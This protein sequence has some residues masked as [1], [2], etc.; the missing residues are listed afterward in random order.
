[1]EVSLGLVLYFR[2]TSLT[3]T[4]HL[5]QGEMCFIFIYN[6]TLSAGVPLNHPIEELKFNTAL[7]ALI[8]VQKISV[9]ISALS[10]SKTEHFRSFFSLANQC[11]QGT[12]LW[13]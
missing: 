1:M 6:K 4:A 8:Y 9:I 5:S 7:L 3:F 13:L 12:T 11:Y 10:Q 2:V